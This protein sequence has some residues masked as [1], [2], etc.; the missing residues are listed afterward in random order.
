MSDRVR[1]MKE[2][3]EYEFYR[4]DKK[5][6]VWWAYVKGYKGIHIFSFDKMKTY[7]LFHDYPYKLSPVEKAIFDEYEP[8]WAK[9]FKKRQL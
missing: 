7:N 2:K 9:F 3:T 6:K 8:F 4:K 1:G 5:S